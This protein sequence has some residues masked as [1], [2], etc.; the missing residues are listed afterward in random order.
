MEAYKEYLEDQGL[1][2]TTVRNHIR[3][4]TKYSESFNLS[5]NQDKTLDNLLTYA[6]GSQRQTMVS[7]IS[8]YRGFMNYDNEKIKT[9]VGAALAKTLELNKATNQSKNLPPL[10][11]FKKRMNQYYKEGKFKEYVVMYLLIHLNVRNMDLV[12][13][14][15]KDATDSNNYFI[16][17]Q[18]ISCLF[19]MLIKPQKNTGQK[20]TKSWIRNF[21][22]R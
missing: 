12:V 15:Q 14:A 8:K 18:S 19:E 20:Q 2:K 13:V 7:T 11:F 10:S 9:A 4:L 21:V 5:D 16:I 1:A 3:N 17:E 22:L 6:E